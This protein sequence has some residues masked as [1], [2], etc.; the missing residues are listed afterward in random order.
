[1]GKS[2]KIAIAKHPFNRRGKFTLKYYCMPS[3]QF[4][5]MKWKGNK[6]YFLFE[7]YFCLFSVPRSLMRLNHGLEIEEI[8]EMVNFQ[9]YIPRH[10]QTEVLAAMILPP[11]LITRRETIDA[12][13]NNIDQSAPVDRRRLTIHSIGQVVLGNQPVRSFF[14][15][16]FSW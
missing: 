5:L 8:D 4:L 10:P 7:N 1:M 14:F 15:K 11:R 6:K 12:R 2:K 3:I 9:L 16:F 13:R